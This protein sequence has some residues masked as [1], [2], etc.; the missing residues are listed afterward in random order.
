[1]E[2]VPYRN[3]EILVKT[4]PKNTLLFRIPRNS[5]DDFKGAKLEDGTRCLTPNYNVYFHPNPFVGHISLPTTFTSL[6]SSVFVYKLKKDIKVLWLLNPSRYSRRTKNSKS[7]FVKRCST[8]KKGCLPS[9]GKYFD[10]C[11][12]DTMIKN[13]PDIVGM[14]AISGGD[15]AILRK[16]LK[17]TVRFKKYLNGAMDA[18]KR[19]GIPELVLHPLTKRPSEDMISPE[20]KEHETN[21]EFVK[22]LD[23]KNIP[24]LISF[25][26]RHASYNPETFFYTYIE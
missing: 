26:E 5:I 2:T 1:M 4:I 17:K 3:T 25:M 11:L 23:K 24:K 9:E 8:V 22:K 7:M 21:Y 20:S 13:Y 16:N 6:E 15:N 14:I 12:S 18:R 10:P 19:G